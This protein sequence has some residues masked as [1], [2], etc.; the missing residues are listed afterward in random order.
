MTSLLPSR[1]RRAIRSLFAGA[2]VMG[3][4][5][6]IAPAT[7]RTAHAQENTS[8]NNGD[9]MNTRLFRAAVDSKGVFTVNGTDVLAAGDLAFGLVLD[10]GFGLLRMREMAAIGT[11]VPPTAAREKQLINSQFHGVLFI[12]YSP[13]KNFTVGIGL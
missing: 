1:R 3:T 4:C 6:A 10:G 11:T 2:A 5:A 9:G 7:T 13:F 12:S 8:L